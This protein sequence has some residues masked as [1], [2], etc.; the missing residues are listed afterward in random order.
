MNRKTV[1]LATL[2]GLATVAVTA[3]VSGGTTAP[4]PLPPTVNASGALSSGNG[5]QPSPTKSPT[6]TS[7]TG[8]NQSYETTTLP[9]LTGCSVTVSNP[10]PLRGQTAETVTVTSAPGALAS[11]TANY[12]RTPSR[13]SA[14]IGTSGSASFALPI[15][16][17]PVGVTV[18][19]NAKVSLRGL[20]VTCSASFTPVL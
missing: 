9:P 18:G 6:T 12:T 17:A 3:T 8:P 16:H 10:A 5:N 11:V 19:V 14:V 2:A 20:S 4:L 7:T 13:H 1:I 15:E